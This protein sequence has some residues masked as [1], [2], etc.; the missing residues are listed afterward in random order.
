MFTCSRF[1]R[2]ISGFLI[3]F[4]V[5]CKE[6]K[7]QGF[8]SIGNG[9][10]YKL[11]TIGEGK[12]KPEKGDF[13]RMKIR[14]YNG[15][16][17]LSESVFPDQDWFDTISVKDPEYDLLSSALTMLVE[18]DS[19]TFIFDEKSPFAGYDTLLVPAYQRSPI[20]LDVKLVSLKE[21]KIVKKERLLRSLWL[22]E[23]RH[24][25]FS[26]INSFVIDNNITSKADADHF[27]YIET[28]PGNG[29]LPRDGQSVTVSYKASFISGK[30]F[31][32]TFETN[33][34]FEFILGAPGQVLPGMDRGIR[35]MREGGKARFIVPSHLAFGETG[36]ST[37][38]VGPFRTLIFDV[39]LIKLK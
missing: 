35:K 24:E 12:K 30:E 6:V 3:V 38:L 11:H 25:E 29:E 21:E 20:K 8:S 10:F 39:E 15:D 37:G 28:S 32:S 19:A 18:G 4:A 31:Y 16:S 22:K 34:S 1:V 27:Y 5:S 23:K 7:Y 36:S 33:D 9:T 14:A 13:L 17:L 2:I 26:L